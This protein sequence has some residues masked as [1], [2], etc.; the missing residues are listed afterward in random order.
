[1][2]LNLLETV[3]RLEALGE[4]RMMWMRTFACFA[5]LGLIAYG[6]GAMTHDDAPQRPY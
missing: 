1:M 2:L 6:L 5:C 4:Q 3:S